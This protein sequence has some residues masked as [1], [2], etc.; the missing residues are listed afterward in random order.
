MPPTAKEETL[1]ILIIKFEP[2]LFSLIA[3]RG[4]KNDCVDTP[5]GPGVTLPSLVI[6]NHSIPHGISS[7]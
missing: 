3:Q 2:D 5:G 6:L 4:P 1:S 7:P